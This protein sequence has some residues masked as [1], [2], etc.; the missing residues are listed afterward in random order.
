MVMMEM[1]QSKGTAVMTRLEATLEM[2][3][4]LVVLERILSSEERM[5]IP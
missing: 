4:L 3:I 2:T 5:M 1:T